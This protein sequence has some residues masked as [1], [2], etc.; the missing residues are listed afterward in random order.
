M[1]DASDVIKKKITPE[2]REFLTDWMTHNHR[3][4]TE[5]AAHFCRFPGGMEVSFTLKMRET[6]DGKF[7]ITTGDVTASREEVHKAMAE[8]EAKK[9][10][11]KGTVH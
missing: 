4:L 11:A 7:T 6:E 5:L 9:A 1:A 2:D 8:H 10:Q 3:A